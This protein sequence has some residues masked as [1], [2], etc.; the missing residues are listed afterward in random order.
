LNDSRKNIIDNLNKNNLIYS[1]TQDLQGKRIRVIIYGTAERGGLEE[2]RENVNKF[3]GIYGKQA[4]EFNAH[5]KEIGDENSRDSATQ[6]AKEIVRNYE[7]SVGKKRL[8]SQRL[9]ND[10]NRGESKYITLTHSSNQDKSNLIIDPEK[11][12]T[13]QAGAEKNR[14]NQ[15]GFRKQS[16]FFV[17][18]SKQASKATEW[19]AFKGGNIYET[20]VSRSKLYDLKKDSANLSKTLS[21][22]EINNYLIDNGMW[23]YTLGDK[24]VLFKKTLGKRVYP[25]K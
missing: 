4:S 13:A 16:A 25:N 1:T 5:I 2:L 6:R 24:A 22:N 21:Q 20:K 18:D 23:G 8:L 17:G 7:T 11:F 10:Y 14:M 12:G 9:R 3:G 19:W 15:P